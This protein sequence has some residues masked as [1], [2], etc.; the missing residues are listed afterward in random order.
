MECSTEVF[1]YP[2]QAC[3]AHRPESWKQHWGNWLSLPGRQQGLKAELEQSRSACF[4]SQWPHN[5]DC[6]QIKNS[7]GFSRAG[8]EIGPS[9]QVEV[10]DSH[11]LFNHFRVMEVV[12]H[13]LLPCLQIGENAHAVL[14]PGFWDQSPSLCS[15]SICLAGL[16]HSPKQFV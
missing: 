8:Q 1:N 10:W 15:I 11:K 14:T 7:E 6:E 2:W 4:L 5:V 3:K 9:W 12:I 16:S 13:L